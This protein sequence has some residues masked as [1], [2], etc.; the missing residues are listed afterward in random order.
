LC[1]CDAP[2]H[3]VHAGQEIAQQAVLMLRRSRDLLM[4]GGFAPLAALLKLAARTEFVIPSIAALGVVVCISAR[5]VSV[6][7]PS[8]SSDPRRWERHLF[9]D[10]LRETMRLAGRPE[11]RLHPLSTSRSGS[12][13]AV[14]G[15]Q[16][17]V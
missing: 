16:L 4:L 17:R 5:P 14:A 12:D 3:A 1:G 15:A 6:L 9:R 10:P 8:G 11:L 7:P 13:H 2:E